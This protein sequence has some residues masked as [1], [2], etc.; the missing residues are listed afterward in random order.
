MSRSRTMCCVWKARSTFQPT[1]TSSLSIRNTMLATMPVHLRFEQDRSGSDHG[2]GGRR[3]AHIDAAEGE[4]RLASQDRGE[5]TNRRTRPQG[6][7]PAALPDGAKRA[8]DRNSEA[9]LCGAASRRRYRSAP[10]HGWT[11]SSDVGRNRSRG[12]GLCLE[13]LSRCFGHILHGI[14]CAHALCLV[15]GGVAAGDEWMACDSALA[16]GVFRRSTRP[17]V[18]SDNRL[19]DRRIVRSAFAALQSAFNK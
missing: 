11:C 5:L 10:L 7:G 13:A 2:A 6:P 8:G 14:R 16:A 3:C 18:P 17:M 4:G 12:Q 1:R 15:G 9:G 19:A